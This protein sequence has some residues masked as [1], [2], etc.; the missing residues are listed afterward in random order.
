[1]DNQLTDELR[2]NLRRILHFIL[3]RG[4]DAN[5]AATDWY[6]VNGLEFTEKSALE[7]NDIAIDHLIMKQSRIRIAEKSRRRA[8]WY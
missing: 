7:V 4:G 2:V 1:M 5:Q 6:E 3:D 8:R